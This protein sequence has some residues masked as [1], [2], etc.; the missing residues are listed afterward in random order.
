MHMNRMSLGRGFS[1]CSE[2]N[3]TKFGGDVTDS[4]PD[5]KESCKKNK[6]TS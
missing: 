1:D 5:Y 6:K 3:H 2:F 4:V